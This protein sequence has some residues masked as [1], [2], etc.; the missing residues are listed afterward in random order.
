MTTPARELFDVNDDDEVGDIDCVSSNL[1]LD[2]NNHGVA[3]S[4]TRDDE[5][6]GI[7]TTTATTSNGTGSGSTGTSRSPPI[8]VGVPLTLPDGRII[9]SKNTL[10]SFHDVN[11]PVITASNNQL[12]SPTTA[13]DDDNNRDGRMN[14]TPLRTN[15]GYLPDGR[16]IDGKNTL[17]SF[18]VSN[19]AAV[20]VVVDS[21]NGRRQNIDT[22]PAYLPNVAANT[23]ENNI[24]RNIDT[25]TN[26]STVHLEATVVRSVHIVKAEIVD[27]RR[28]LFRQPKF[29]LVAMI[30]G[31][32]L[33]GVATGIGVYCGT[34]NCGGSTIS[35]GSSSSDTTNNNDDDAALQE[36]CEF[37]NFKDLND[38]RSATSWEGES[39]YYYGYE[40]NTTIPSGIG[41]LT[42]LTR[43]KFN[44]YFE[45]YSSRVLVGSIPSSIGNLVHLNYLN[46]SYNGLTGTIP[47]SIGSLTGLTTLDLFINQLSGPI[48]PS[49]G[50]SIT[51]LVHLDLDENNLI[52]TVPKS[53]GNLVALT[54]L[55]IDNNALTGTIPTEIGNLQ[56]LSVLSLS[57]NRLIGAIPSSIGN[58][59]N[60]VWLSL[61]ANSL[62]GTMPPDIGNLIQLT[63]FNASVNKFAGM[64]PSSIGS[65]SGLT[66]LTLGANSLSGTIPSFIW[67][68]AQLTHLDL[69]VNSFTGAIST[70]I[71]N[72]IYLSELYI[73]TNDGVTGTIPSQIGN[74]QNL[75][76][77]SL[78]DNSLSGT[79]PSTLGNL[80]QL[81]ELY[82]SNNALSG[83]IPTSFEN[84][85]SLDILYLYGNTNVNGTVP[86]VLCHDSL[87]QILKVDC[88]NVLCDSICCRNGENDFDFCYA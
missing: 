13:F 38:C 46:F 43:L 26:D 21:R 57:E 7:V 3:A 52:G 30:L 18:D 60:L 77:L 5:A 44:G 49:I 9:D 2:S 48:P 65:I 17:Q 34:G 62:S 29:W 85:N 39:P 55:Y 22:N 28:E 66:S 8:L 68:L 69:G 82:L 70:E 63:Y 58:L 1:R 6:T 47:T 88:E 86:Y 87:S 78:S 27:S 41:L 83:E 16:M 36:I 25:N 19:R 59:R 23:N 53:L 42:Q 24:D 72:L 37:F 14:T 73:D 20:V 4:N 51:T 74:L 33:V 11:H 67:S 31:M 40:Y 32:I 71:G 64:V 79:I 10:R 80:V 45:D 15:D 12:R 50:D 61:E 35:T 81:T 56:S 84:L 76:I 75:L 54:A